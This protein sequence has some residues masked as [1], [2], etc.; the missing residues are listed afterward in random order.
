MSRDW[1]ELPH[2]SRDRDTAGWMEQNLGG[3]WFGFDD[4]L[5][6]I[7]VA[8]VCLALLVALWARGALLL[9]VSGVVAALAGVCGRLLSVTTWQVSAR[10]GG[11]GLVRVVR[12]SSHSRRTMRDVAAMLA[13]GE[14]PSVDGRSGVAV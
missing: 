6:G 14:E 4:S 12:D 8:I 10:G 13:R 9:L 2:W 3:D 1:F 11:R 7:V 5:V